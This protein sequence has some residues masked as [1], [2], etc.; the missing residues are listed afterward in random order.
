[1]IPCMTA[2][3]GG[4]AAASYSL[5]SVCWWTLCMYK[6][7]GYRNCGLHIVCKWVW[8]QSRCGFQM[9]GLHWLLNAAVAVCVCVFLTSSWCGNIWN[10]VFKCKHILEHW[11][12]F[13][14]DPHLRSGG[15]ISAATSPNQMSLSVEYLSPQI[16][17]C[18][19]VCV[20]VGTAYSISSATSNEFCHCATSK[21]ILN[22]ICSV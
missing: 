12:P 11:I 2:G 3:E 4:R 7:G 19:C 15:L 8:K 9:P 13:G 1:M 17:V 16:P 5:Y 14:L 22:K 6:E 21:C 18:V 20:C 10:T